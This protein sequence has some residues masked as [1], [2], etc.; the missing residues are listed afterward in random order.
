[1]CFEL[2]IPISDG[3][4]RLSSAYAETDQEIFNA[5]PEDIRYNWFGNSIQTLP[6]DKVAISAP[7]TPKPNQRIAGEVQIFTILPN[8]TLQLSQIISDPTFPD[9]SDQFGYAMIQADL[10][11]D[12]KVRSCLIIGAP[13]SSYGIHTNGGSV[14][15][16]DATTFELLSQIHSNRALGRFGRSFGQS[17]DYLLIGAPRYHNVRK[18]Q[19]M[20]KKIFYINVDFRKRMLFMRKGL[21][22]QSPKPKT[23]LLETSL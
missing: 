16:Y 18:F 23:Y 6:N 15:I 13:T 22:L 5:N 8:S 4:V 2:T 19:S 20:Y 17:K 21:S 9:E 1:M 3:I 11:V 14:Y 10:N 7:L 12:N